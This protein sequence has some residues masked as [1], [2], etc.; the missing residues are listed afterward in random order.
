MSSTLV[1]Q[2][3]GLRVAVFICTRVSVGCYRRRRFFKF[4]RCLP[5]RDG[6]STASGPFSVGSDDGGGND[7]FSTPN[8]SS[9]LLAQRL[10]LWFYGSCY[11]FMSSYSSSSSQLVC[12]WLLLLLSLV[13]VVVVA[14][15]LVLV[16][17]V[18]SLT[19]SFSFYSSETE[20]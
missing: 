5:S 2:R 18:P 19:L 6:L 13:L 20:V 15:V 12:L 10:V 4:A 3:R 11:C 9:Q 7:E 8:P 17:V 14:A 1:S 16:L